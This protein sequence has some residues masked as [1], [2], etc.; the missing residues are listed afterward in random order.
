LAGLKTGVVSSWIFFKSFSEKLFFLL[1]L[2]C[3]VFGRGDADLCG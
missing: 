2:P 3:F 1:F